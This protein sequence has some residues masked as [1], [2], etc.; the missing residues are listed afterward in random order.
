MHALWGW[1]T[2]RTAGD[3]ERPRL[4][5]SLGQLGSDPGVD[6]LMKGLSG[7]LVVEAY[8]HTQAARVVLKVWHKHHRLGVLFGVH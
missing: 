3:K 1:G 4:A 5:S 6:T 7:I 8:P 2:A